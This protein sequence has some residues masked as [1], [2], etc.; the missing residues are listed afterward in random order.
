MPLLFFQGLPNEIIL[1]I[2]CRSV[3]ERLQSQ[4]HKTQRW[5]AGSELRSRT[6]SLSCLAAQRG[7]E[8]RGWLER[9]R[10][11]FLPPCEPWFQTPNRCDH[12]AEQT[13]ARFKKRKTPQVLLLSH[14]G[15]EG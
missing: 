15:H 13:K 7:Q 3:L 10:R 11:G 8:P 6:R 5:T 14:E 4:G 9:G 12:K 1:H 2:C